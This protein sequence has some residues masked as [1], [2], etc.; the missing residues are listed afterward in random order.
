MADTFGQLDEV[1][2][3]IETGPAFDLETKAVSTV[4]EVV[5]GYQTKIDVSGGV[6]KRSFVAACDITEPALIT[7]ATGY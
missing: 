2:I 6:P 4:Y 5:A 7:P 3:E 1:Q